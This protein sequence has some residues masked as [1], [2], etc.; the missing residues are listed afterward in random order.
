MLVTG[1][2]TEDLPYNEFIIIPTEDLIINGYVDPRNKELG[3]M[4]CIS[5]NVPQKNWWIKTITYPT[6]QK[7][8]KRHNP[9]GD[10]D[11]NAIPEYQN[12]MLWSDSY[13]SLFV[14]VEGKD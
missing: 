14:T 4:C 1:L 10:Y 3:Y 9:F 2:I 7:M 12:V 8:R 5:N 11:E 13:I 6:I